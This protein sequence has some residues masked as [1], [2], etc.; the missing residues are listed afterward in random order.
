MTARAPAKA[1][2]VVARKVEA[3]LAEYLKV[4]PAEVSPRSLMVEDLAVD[5]LI[6]AELLIEL[7]NAFDVEFGLEA[8][9]RLMDVKTVGDLSAVVAASIGKRSNRTAP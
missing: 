8:V 2:P 3:V 6:A 7:E 1:S 5:S 4:K 9:E